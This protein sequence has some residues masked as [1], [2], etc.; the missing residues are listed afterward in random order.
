MVLRPVDPKHNPFGNVLEVIAK[1]LQTPDHTQTGD[2]IVL[3]RILPFE[4]GFVIV[5]PI[6]HARGEV[7]IF[8]V[9]SSAKV[10]Q[11]LE[12]QFGYRSNMLAVEH[13]ERRIFGDVTGVIPGPFMGFLR[14]K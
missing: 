12:D 5:V 11:H 10:A 13:R 9:Q 8:I 2:Q 14:E 6:C 7:R 1:A 4:H 3:V